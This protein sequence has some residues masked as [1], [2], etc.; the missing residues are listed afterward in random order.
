MFTQEVRYTMYQL[1]QQS[2][3]LKKIFPLVVHNNILLSVVS[4]LQHSTHW[5]RI[6]L[7]VVFTIFLK[8]YFK[9]YLSSKEIVKSHGDK[10]LKS[11]S[12]K[13]LPQCV[14]DGEKEGDCTNTIKPGNLPNCVN[15]HSLSLNSPPTPPEIE[16]EQTNLTLIL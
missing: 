2:E 6:V 7:E 11:N 3:L 14:V 15:R 9:S 1:Q 12:L 16:V 5:G 8:K 4:L 10:D 13:I